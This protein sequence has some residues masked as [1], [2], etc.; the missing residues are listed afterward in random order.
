MVGDK[1]GCFRQVNTKNVQLFEYTT[2]PEFNQ[3][4]TENLLSILFSH[5]ITLELMSDRNWDIALHYFNYFLDPMKYFLK[6]NIKNA[7]F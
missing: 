7:L 3:Q 2:L 5:N 4:E 6:P 1:K